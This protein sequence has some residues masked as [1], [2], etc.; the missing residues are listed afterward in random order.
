MRLLIA[1]LLLALPWSALAFAGWR[2]FAGGSTTIYDLG[3]WFG[4]APA[5]TQWL[6]DIF[7]DAGPVGQGVVALTWAGGLLVL[8]VLLR[9]LARL[10]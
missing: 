6:A 4:Y 3:R 9:G 1:F 7:A 10:R 8:G 2:A 5:R